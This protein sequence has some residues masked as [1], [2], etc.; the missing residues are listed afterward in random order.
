MLCTCMSVITNLFSYVL[1]TTCTCTCT[2]L[3]MYMCCA[4]E[5]GW[6]CCGWEKG[7]RGHREIMVDVLVGDQIYMYLLPSFPLHH[8]YLAMHVIGI[9]HANS[10][11]A[12]ES[13]S[14]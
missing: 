3:Y 14:H 10:L 9:V 13:V 6:Y 8:T 4:I 12:H 5:W 1:G 2:L 11:W 7:G